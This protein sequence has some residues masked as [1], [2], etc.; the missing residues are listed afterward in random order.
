MKRYIPLPM[1]LNLQ[2]TSHALEQDDPTTHK[3]TGWEGGK[4]KTAP[5][6]EIRPGT[7]ASSWQGTGATLVA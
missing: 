3:K 2:V 1:G 4:I 5:L 7:R 6:W